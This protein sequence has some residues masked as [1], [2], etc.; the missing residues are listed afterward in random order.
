[1]G[2]HSDEPAGSPAQL[3]ASGRIDVH[4]HFVPSEWRDVPAAVAPLF[5][6]FT[7]WS[8]LIQAL[9][10]NPLLQPG[11]LEMIQRHNALQLF[12]RLRRPGAA[13]G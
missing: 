7:S 1:M 11:D 9:A 4:A 13:A 5:R 3:A 10:S 6:G 2:Q 8:S 12:P